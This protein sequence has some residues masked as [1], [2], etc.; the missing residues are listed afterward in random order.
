MGPHLP[1]SGG[2]NLIWALGGAC[3]KVR[4]QRNKGRERSKLKP[5]KGGPGPGG[6]LRLEQTQGRVVGE[7]MCGEAGRDPEAVIRTDQGKDSESNVKK[8]WEAMEGF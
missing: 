8:R 5:K 2:P 7:V 6:T 3:L 1:V 4:S